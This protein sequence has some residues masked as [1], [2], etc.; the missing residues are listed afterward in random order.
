MSGR[1]NTLEKDAHTEGE[2][3]PVKD[4][5]QDYVLLDLSRNDTHS[6]MRVWRKWF[7][8][9]RRDQ[10][11]ENDTIRVMV[12]I[13]DTEELELSDDHTF[14]K[15]IFFLEVLEHIMY[16]DNV[17]IHEFKLTDHI[18]ADQDTSYACTFLPMPRVSKK[19]HIIKYEPVEDPDTIGIVHH[20][21][22]YVCGNNTILMSDVG[23]C[24]GSDSRYAQCMS[25]TFGW[26]VGGE[27]FDY[28]SNCGVSVGTPDDPLYV[29]I[30]IHYSNFENKEGLK[31]SS[32]MRI[33]YTP[34]LRPHD[35]STLM[36]GIFTFPIEFIPPGS[37]AFRNYGL[38][39]TNLLE[40]MLGR[41][42]PDLTVTTFLLHGHLTA[43]GLR[44]MHY[45]N[46]TLI[47]SLGED[48]KYDFSFQQV[49]NLPREVTVKM[50][51]QIVV[52]CTS[53]TMDRE[54]N[55]YGGPSTLNE[56]CIGFVFYYPAIPVA[57]CW[58]LMDI[59]YVTNALGLD[60]ADSIM[61]AI[62]NIDAVEWDDE[63]K[64]IAQKAVMEAPH[65]AVV[66]NR[67]GR[68]VNETSP[69]PPISLP[70]PFHCEDDTLD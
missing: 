47:G 64:K 28:P 56:M 17:L 34:D 50:G 7:T 49:R 38:C 68:R 1:I 13:G 44:I 58:S 53:S 24:Y 57:S 41:P 55:T 15:S 36:T 16:P 8:C 70:P 11:I 32:G 40:T 43:R 65:L 69:L 27:S 14:R 9:D 52:E 46:G 66:E 5:S 26:A 19:H 30:E 20:I 54:G 2:W 60:K 48:K 4:K 3:P 59:H 31:D 12:V 6:I 33:Y 45:R 22:I 67:E 29:R 37:T 21:L 10:E 18:V 62:L 39:N 61:D 51:D 23:D 63:K 35:C 25:A 42:I